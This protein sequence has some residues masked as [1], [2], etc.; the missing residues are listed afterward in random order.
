VVDGTNAVIFFNNQHTFT[1]GVTVGV[2]TF[3][4]FLALSGNGGAG[5]GNAPGQ[6][7]TGG[8]MIPTNV[9]TVNGGAT[10]SLDGVA[11]L[12]N[13]TMV[14]AFAPSIHI[15]E[16]STLYGGTNTVAFV[17]NITLDGGKIQITDGANHGGFGTDL[18]FVGTVVVGGSST[19]P[20]T[21]FTTGTG[22]NANAS[23]GSAALP[24]TTFDV[25]N[26]TGDSAADLTVSTNLRN[27]SNLTSPLV[28]TGPGTMVLSGTNT[29]TGDTT[30]LGGELTVN[31]S[32]I[33]DTNK[34]VIDGGK[35]G[36]VA[37]ANETVKTLFFGAI[38]QNAGTY[39]SSASGATHQDDTRFSGTGIVTVTNGPLVTYETWA[40]IITNGL[41]MRTDDADG[42][43][44][45]NLQE[46]LFG[47]SPISGQGS[48]TTTENTG[49]GLIVRWCERLGSG[50]TYVLQ[51]STDLSTW[52]TSAVIPTVDANQAA[53][54]S[55]SYVRKQ[56]ILP[57][58]GGSK[59][60][61]VQA[62]E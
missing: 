31:G 61:R 32:S 45:N 3:D 55:D 49:S 46:F 22:A 23:L 47:T 16:N 10:L 20:S 57:I 29:Y 1:N 62:T 51:E 6:F 7:C 5:A 26:V 40:A 9:I 27:V 53:L 41:N 18:T 44:V 39:G 19:V 38:Q 28:K 33:A 12:G 50:S 43:G 4:G 2:N 34:L 54:Y 25:A 48:L 8:A 60:A 13:S 56:A 52:T 42:D 35:I 36:V 15:N 30:V 14:P 17:P 58:T 24:G 11:P 59:F 37:A 21:I